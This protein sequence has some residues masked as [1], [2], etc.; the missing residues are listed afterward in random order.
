HPSPTE[1]YYQVGDEDDHEAWRLPD[2]DCIECDPSWE[3]RAVHYGVGAN[4]AGRTAA[5]L[6]MGSR[7]YRRHDRAFAARCL[8]A[9]ESVYK[10]GLN[11]RRIVST[12][13]GDF[14]PEKTWED[15]M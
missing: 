14:Y 5:A 2:V 11:N 4:L 12:L 9:A 13:P 3:P 7:I 15:D 8:A 10:L 1:L 6:A